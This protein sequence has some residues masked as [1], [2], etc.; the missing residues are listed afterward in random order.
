[1]TWEYSCREEPVGVLF[2]GNSGLDVGVVSVIAPNRKCEPGSK[3][4]PKKLGVITVEGLV[5]APGQKITSLTNSQVLSLSKAAQF[6]YG[7]KPVSSIK[8]ARH[9]S[10][11]WMLARSS[12]TC[13]DRRG[14]VAGKDSNGNLALA[15]LS[16][17]GRRTCHVSQ[18]LSA[19]TLTAPLVGPEDGPMPKVFGLKVFGTA[20]N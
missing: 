3:D 15:S 14:L 12:M 16:A 7:L 1:M 6:K 18:S 11:D 19:T 17:G 20:I 4:L 13:S 9:G 8:L 10:G 5:I 2:T